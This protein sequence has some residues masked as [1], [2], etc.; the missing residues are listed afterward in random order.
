[1]KKHLYEP[2]VAAKQEPGFP[3]G[4][5]FR[6]PATP[7][8]DTKTFVVIG[9]HRYYNLFTAQLAQSP[10]SHTGD[11]KGPVTILNP[12]ELVWQSNKP[13]ELKFYAAI[14]KLQTFY[15]ASPADLEGLK[16]LIR[17]PFGHDFYFHEES[18]SEKIT[19]RSLVPVQVSQPDIDYSIRIGLQ[20]GMYAISSDLYVA[21][22]F[23]PL[24]RIAIRFDYFL[25]LNHNWFLCKNLNLLQAVAYFKKQDNCIVLPQDAFFDFRKE[26]LREMENYLPVQHTYL[27]PAT[28]SQ[29]AS[30][31][32][33]QVPEKLIYLSDQENYVVLNPVMRYGDMEIPVL[34]RRQVYGQ[35]PAGRLFTVARNGEAEDAFTA[36]LLRQHA[37]FEE[38]L[39]NPLPYFYLH[40]S[41]FLDEDWFLKAFA[42]WSAQ[43]IT[44]LGFNALKGNKLNQHKVNISIHVLSGFNW[45]NAKVGVRFGSNKAS[46]KQVYKAVKNKHKYIQLDDGTLGILPQ[47]WLEK[48][49][50]YFQVGE[51]ANEE[52]LRIPK[53]NYTALSELY[54]QHLLSEEVKLEINRY[55]EQLADFATLKPVL[56]P[57]ELQAVL[58]P[59]QLQGLSWLNFLDEL[60]F[61]A[62]LA[63]DMGLGKTVQVIAFMLLLREKSG[64]NTHLLVVPTSLL[65]NW[66]SEIQKF[67]PGLHL[68]LLHG[69]ER[70]KSTDSF[71]A[72]DLVLT[73]YSTLL[74]DVSFLKRY[75]FSYIFLDESQNIKNPASQRYKAARLLQSRNKVVITGTPV[76]NSPSDLYA[77]LSFACPGLLGTRQYFRNTYAIPI[78][79]FKDTKRALALQ[80][81]V[82]PF[83]LRRTKKEVATELPEKTEMVLYCKMGPRQREVYETCER[84]FREYIAASGE[85]DISRKTMHVLRGITKLRQICNSPLLIGEDL[86]SAG[87]SSKISL[88]LEQIRHISRQHKVLVFS[89]FVSMLELIKG[90]LVKEGIPYTY[91]TGSTRNRGEVVSHFQE[92]EAP[93]VF[94]I[95]LKA[96]G[97][98]LNLTAADYVFI[99]DPW[100]NPAVENQAI[101][102]CYRIGQTKQ[103]IAVRLICPDTVEEKILLMQQHKAKLASDLIPAENKMLQSLSKRELLALVSS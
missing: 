3:V 49:E 12:M 57:E 61:G 62:C 30:G 101:D 50:R 78:D 4:E 15:E 83:I 42:D 10:L 5:G 95:S 9:K 91:L 23:C 59:Y 88:L 52:T 60:N 41:R 13:E 53:V 22:T 36:L 37:D 28:P 85:G 86:P 25:V 48:L 51:V 47:E 68:L 45:F 63:D 6:T 98:G 11:L 72:F 90:E 55:Q 96:G 82:S 38:Q 29:L 21:N 70:V 87:S 71:D 94:L 33:D 40:K 14:S 27:K 75:A 18:I 69:P 93:R 97:T 84:E 44:V 56:A 34:S 39:A 32:F 31:G 99:V 46:L 77:Q 2:F 7:V 79:R 24:S 17:N 66:R 8:S 100:W 76:E 67:A 20:E 81:K 102:R 89:Q 19:P 64:R 43:E 1:M 26:V 92:S 74:S 16:A 80:Q 58:R 103:V 73:S 54:E 35:D 65:D